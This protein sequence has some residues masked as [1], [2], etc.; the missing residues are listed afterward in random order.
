MRNG[1]NPT[2]SRRCRRGPGTTWAAV[3]GACLAALAM[4]AMPAMARDGFVED[5]DT[6]P[7]A[8]G[9]Q[10]LG[11]AAAFRWEPA[12]WLAVEWDST[13]P[14]GFFAR[15]LPGPVT[16]RDD[17]SFGFDLLLDAH[18]VGVAPGK[19]GTF[20]MA[21][22][23]V[24]RADATQP[25]FRRG[26]FLASRN[27]VEW[28]WFGSEP[29]GLIS[30]SISPVVV[31]ADGRLPWGYADSFVEPQAG[32]RYGFDL[33]YTAADRTLRL[34]MTVDGAPGPALRAV[35]VPQAFTGF[36]VDA[37]SVNAYSDAGQDPRYAGS[38]RASARI[39]RLRWNGPGPV[40]VGLR[41]DAT[42]GGARVRCGTR[43]GWRYTLQASADLHAWTA[44]AGPV[45]GDGGEV[46]L[47]D[48]AGHA[49]RLYRV[50][51]RRP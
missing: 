26:V 2:R 29:S 17:F 19:P 47:D 51:A 33:S 28:A 46:S 3:W 43:A 24:R 20:P 5:F 37:L 39:D 36:E 23:L 30:A 48:A 38:L 49:H 45:T 22:G 18:A 15:E 41:V 9:W 44:V 13:R 25:S 6:E 40:I 27:L 16:E 4:P 10:A 11:D 8:R 35:V 42:P 21:V 12:G 14:N 32:I 31:P 1:G 7:S 34:A 50:E